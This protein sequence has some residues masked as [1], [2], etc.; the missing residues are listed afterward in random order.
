MKKIRQ[1]KSD[2]GLPASL[3]L[4]LLNGAAGF[5]SLI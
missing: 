5:S 3:L 1:W 4:L 2:K